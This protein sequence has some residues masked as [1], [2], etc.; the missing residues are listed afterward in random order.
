MPLRRARY[1]LLLLPVSLV[2]PEIPDG[3]SGPAGRVFEWEE[4]AEGVY[5]AVVR[6]RPAAYAFANSLVV[7]TGDGVLVVDTQQS[8]TAARALIAHL[9]ALTS[10]PV[11]WVVNTHWHGDHVYGNQAYRDA[12]PGVTFIGHAST[13][14][15][16][17]S[18]GKRRLEEDLERLP[19]SIARLDEVLAGGGSGEGSS[20]TDRERTAL[21]YR[22]ALRAAYLE[23]LRG[24][25]LVPPDLTFDRE[26]DLHP[27]GREI[28]IVHVGPAHT[29]G[30]VVVLVPDAGVAAVGDVLDE[31]L[32]W[33]DED[34]S[35][36]GWLAALERIEAL[37]DAV[38]VYV[39]SH[40][41]VQR[42]S[43][44]LEAYSTFFDRLVGAAREG[45]TA[46]GGEREVRAR[47][48]VSEIRRLLALPPSVDDAAIGRFLDRAVEAAVHDRGLPFDTE[49]GS[50]GN[51]RAFVPRAA[52]TRRR[53]RRPGSGPSTKSAVERTSAV[54]PS[55]AV[56]VTCATPR[57]GRP[58]RGSRT[59]P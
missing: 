50:A 22:R 30:D 9:P 44:L 29:R 43:D 28:R 23:D 24:L 4:L 36:A 12:Y 53:S 33:I 48:G 38:S 41:A 26:I 37:D 6:E 34:S 18:K 51:Q 40:G 35:P 11:R 57:A 45:R 31:G 49:A 25:E 42:G 13:R 2:G 21:A 58:V 47:L 55:A 32:P 46:G 14:A 56:T 20:L 19:A 8:P 3:V 54:R 27:G 16:V 52:G 59:W 17:L 1:L 39:P 7:V 15:D 5:A 10:R